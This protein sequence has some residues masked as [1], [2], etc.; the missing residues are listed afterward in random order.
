MIRR[1]NMGVFLDGPLGV[2]GI[3]D[4]KSKACPALC[5][6]SSEKESSSLPSMGS[7]GP[8][9]TNQFLGLIS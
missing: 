7:S 9:M 1:G 8:L 3:H 4:H 5:N 6:L 2:L